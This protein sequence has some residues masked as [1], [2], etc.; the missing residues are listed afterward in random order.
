MA[1]CF[2]ADTSVIV[3]SLLTWHEH[4]APSRRALETAMDDAPLVIPVPALVESYAVLT[5]LPAPH[6]LS[7]RDAHVLLR[8][9]FAASA[10]VDSL[11]GSQCWDMLGGLAARSIAGGRTYDAQILAAAIK[12]G[13]S[14]VLT[15]NAEDFAALA[16]DDI[17]IRNPLARS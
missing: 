11:T 10:Q 17:E 9:N 5:R 3:A 13:A 16:P 15:L 6:R 8:E 1:A 2:A 14:V 12:S 7:P 4:H